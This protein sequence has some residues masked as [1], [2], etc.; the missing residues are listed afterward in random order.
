[1]LLIII[2]IIIIMIIAFLIYQDKKN[3][4]TTREKFLGFGMFS[5]LTIVG[6]F[7]FGLIVNEI[8]GSHELVNTEKTHEMVSLNAKNE[9]SGSF[10]LGCGDISESEYYFTFIKVKDN[11]YKRKKFKSIETRIHETNIDAPSVMKRIYTERTSS[12]ILPDC[13]CP[14]DTKYTLKV[15]KGTIIKEFNIGEGNVQ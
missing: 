6:V 10:V 12:W 3:F 11:T 15:P 2:A 14:N 8:F 7:L 5:L 13:L 4:S 1:M 9:V